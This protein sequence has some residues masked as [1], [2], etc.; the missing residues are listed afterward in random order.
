VTICSDSQAALKALEGAKVTSN[1][2]AE[3]IEAVNK[4]SICNSVRLLWV[5]G[6]CGIPGNETVDGLAKKVA[7]TAFIGP[8][9]VFGVPMCSRAAAR[10]WAQSEQQRLWTENTTCRQAKMFFKGPD[11]GSYPTPAGMS[12]QVSA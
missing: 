11:L 12:S 10:A 9:P 8:E 7:S 6:H 1:L 3:V 2:V 4:V 5:P